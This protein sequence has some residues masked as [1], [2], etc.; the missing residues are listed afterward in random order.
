[1]KVKIG[2]EIHEQLETKTKLYC[3]CSSEYRNAL[4]NTN[5]CEICTGMPGAKPMA[6]NEDAVKKAIKLALMLNC[7][8]VSDEIYIQRKHYDYPDLPNGYQ[9]TSLP[10]GKNGELKG[11]KIWEVHLEE[12]PGKY[13][14]VSGRV[15]YNRCGVPL[16]EIVTA[17]EISSPEE[18]REFLRELVRVF[19]YSNATKKIGGTMRVDVNISIEGG[20]R[21]EIKNINSIKGAYKALNFEITRQKNLMKRGIKIKRETRG[22][23]ES[24]MITVA[25]RTKEEAEDYRYIPDPD[26]MPMLISK[27]EIEKIK[28]SLPET[29]QAKEKRL[30]EQ[31]GITKEEAKVIAGEIELA[32][33]FEEIA[34]HIDAKFA[35]NWI[36]RELIRVLEYNSISFAQSNIKTEYLIELLKMIESKEITVKAG[37]KLMECLATHAESPREICKKLGLYGIEEE[38]IVEKA[39]KAVVE[40]NKKA[41]EDYL[42]GK[43]EALHYL[44]GHVMKKTRGKAEPSAVINKIK[45]FIEMQKAIKK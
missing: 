15:D 7:E 28:Q 35:A 5:I 8:I 25:M 10:I 36:K 9:R 21:V 22:F 38:S 37:Q 6:I 29:P 41:V 39:V 31:Y 16:I 1:M 34:K 26:V 40:E 17:P 32:D 13:D 14:P 42:S 4:P 18:A 20:A 24:Q 43:N 30:M 33:A 19:D 12:D 23:L 11:I 3:S 45:N 2:F 27:E 44:V